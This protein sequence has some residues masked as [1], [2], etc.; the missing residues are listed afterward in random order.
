VITPP[1][2]GCSPAYAMGWND[3]AAGE[4]LPLGSSA[5]YIEGHTNYISSSQE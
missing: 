4:A 1:P 2:A 5:A 3:A